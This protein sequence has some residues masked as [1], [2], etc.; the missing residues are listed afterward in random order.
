MEQPSRPA[1]AVTGANLNIANPQRRTGDDGIAHEYAT[2]TQETKAAVTTTTTPLPTASAPPIQRKWLLW[3]LFVLRC[4]SLIML[5]LVFICLIYGSSLGRHFIP[6]YIFVLPP[7]APHTPSSQANHHPGLS[8]H[9]RHLLHP[10]PQRLHP[11]RARP[12]P[13]PTA[14]HPPHPGRRRRGDARGAGGRHRA[15]PVEHQQHQPRRAVRR[16]VLVGRGGRGKGALRGAEQELCVLVYGGVGGDYVWGGAGAL[17]VDGLVVC[18]GVY[19]EEGGS[20]SGCGVGGAAAEKREV[21]VRR[22]GGGMG[23]DTLLEY[24]VGIYVVSRGGHIYLHWVYR[25]GAGGRW[26]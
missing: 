1:P 22:K 20:A 26:I 11:L 14:A 8:H 4:I 17:G 18:A 25:C 5:L 10:I 6:A 3:I 15:L 2:G 23:W 16:A 7:L 12:Y 24:G 19:Y 9:S 21:C 13:L